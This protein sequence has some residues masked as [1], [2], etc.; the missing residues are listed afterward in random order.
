MLNWTYAPY[1]LALLGGSAVAFGLALYAAR[2][3]ALHGVLPF[4]GI[5]LGTGVL[6]AGYALE[7]GSVAQADKIWSAKTEYLGIATHPPFWLALALYYS[8]PE[9]PGSPAPL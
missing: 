9:K 3:R 5:C 8:G 7:I 1:I 4:M 6:M 2:Y